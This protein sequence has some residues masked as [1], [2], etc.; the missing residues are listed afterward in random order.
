MKLG[1]HGFTKE[2]RVEIVSKTNSQR[3]MCLETGY[4]TSPGALTRYQRNR[5]IDVSKRTQIL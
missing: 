1:I 3:W 5:N 4:I 2:K